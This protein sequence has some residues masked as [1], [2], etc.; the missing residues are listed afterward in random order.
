MR[1]TLIP[2]AAIL[3]VAAAPAFAAQYD[4]PSS[5][6]TTPPAPSTEPLTSSAPAAQPA[7]EANMPK[8]KPSTLVVQYNTAANIKMAQTKLKSLGKYAGPVDGRTNVQFK[9]ALIAFQ[10]D[11]KLE[12]TGRLNAKTLKALKG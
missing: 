12:A 4:S 8:A 9:T 1:R 11:H 10:K 6:A 2:A 5:P 3:A 7:T